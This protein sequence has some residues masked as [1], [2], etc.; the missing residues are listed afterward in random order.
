MKLETRVIRNRGRVGKPWLLV[1]GHYRA[2]AELGDRSPERRWQTVVQIG[3]FNSQ[4]EAEAAMVT[5]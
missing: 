5:I 4:T 1:Q 3:E 2:G